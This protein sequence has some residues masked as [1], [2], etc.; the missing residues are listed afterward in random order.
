M[1]FLGRRSTIDTALEDVRRG[2]ADAE[3]FME[4]CRFDY[5]RLRPTSSP[6]SIERHDDNAFTAS[7]P[8]PRRQSA[9]SASLRRPRAEIR[10]S[11]RDPL[12]SR[13]SREAPV[14]RDSHVP[15][16]S[17]APAESVMAAEEPAEPPVEALP[18]SEGPP[19]SAETVAAVEEPAE[20]PVEELPEIEDPPAAEEQEWPDMPDF[21][22][23]TG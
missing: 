23:R 11:D 19:A 1:S 5:K 14:P 16:D 17:T 8:I 2:L 10:G 20:P 7:R 3:A 4:I 13:V 15:H 21:L 18:T 6:P 9:A 12:R 22:V